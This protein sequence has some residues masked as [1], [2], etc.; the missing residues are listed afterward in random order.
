MLCQQNSALKR[1][2]HVTA[3][4]FD[5]EDEA[6]QRTFASAVK[7][8]NKERHENEELPNV[9]LLQEMPE[10]ETDPFDMTSTGKME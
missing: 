8:V 1:I 6:I 5:R 7:A 9:Y 10:I 3:G 4:L 2:G